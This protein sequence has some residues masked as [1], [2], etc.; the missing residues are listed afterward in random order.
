MNADWHGPE[1][2]KP[3]TEARRERKTLPLIHTDHTDSGNGKTY[4]GVG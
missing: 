3:T 1:R 2:Q 4:H